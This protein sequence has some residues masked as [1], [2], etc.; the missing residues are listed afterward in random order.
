MRQEITFVIYNF[1]PGYKKV[2]PGE[3]MPLSKDY[4]Q[5]GDLIIEFNI[6]FPSTLTPERKELLRRALPM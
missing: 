1:R 3:G 2:V 6:K 4:T 5:K